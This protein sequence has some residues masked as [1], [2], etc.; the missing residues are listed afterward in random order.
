MGALKH[1]LAMVMGIA[2]LFVVSM[3][4]FQLDGIYIGVTRTAEMRNAMLLSLLIFLGFYR[5]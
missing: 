3:W 1:R 4:S 5:N 2:S